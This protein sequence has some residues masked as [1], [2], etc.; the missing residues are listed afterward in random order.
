MSVSKI[1]ANTDV[2][3]KIPIKN[4][5]AKKVAV[6]SI[7]PDNYKKEGK[8]QDEELSSFI[9]NKPRSS[10]II[11][12]DI[13]PTEEEEEYI[14]NLKQQTLKIVEKGEKINDA[15]S[16]LMGPGAYLYDL[17]TD[18]NFGQMLL[19][20]T[21]AVISV[22]H[23]DQFFDKVFGK[24]FQE[25]GVPNLQYL[26]VDESTRL[27]QLIN[28][29]IDQMGNKIFHTNAKVTDWEGGVQSFFELSEGTFG[30]YGV[31]QGVVTD[32]LENP[33]LKIHK[34]IYNYIHDLGFKQK[35]ISKV[36]SMINETGAC[37][38]AA[39]VSAI[40]YQFKDNP[41]AFER[42]FGYP[43]KNEDGTLNDAL[44]LTD[45][46]IFVNDV[47]NGGELF[48]KKNGKY[49]IVDADTENQQYLSDVLGTNEELVDLFLKSKNKSLSYDV[50]CL[51]RKKEGLEKYEDILPESEKYQN[52]LSVKHEVK[53][54]LLQ[55][56]S[57]TLSVYQDTL[58]NVNFI[59][60][61]EENGNARVLSLSDGAHAVYVTGVIDDDERDGL[62][63]SSYGNKY[64]VSWD[65][66]ANAEFIISSASIK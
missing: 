2:N 44:L 28:S 5:T 24:T 9:S 38:Y 15:I 60:M 63:V 52:I 54:H 42:I 31:D 40:M 8:N 22:E 41:E 1:K 30:N 51:V 64:Y 14:E 43:L 50:E 36:M 6:S 66:L 55:D 13:G 4:S 11:Y 27:G 37:S 35:D 23:V 21:N 7:I 29:Y 58:D 10:E 20:R 32:I 17:L 65:N 25:T 45:I 3:V 59:P 16:T 34:Q 56:Q 49:R 53:S 57:V 18:G 61:D 19:E 33:D 47:E 12:E 26:H 39:I 48:Q 62:V 46:Y